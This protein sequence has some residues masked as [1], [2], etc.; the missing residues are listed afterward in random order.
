VTQ[1][2]PNPTTT[3][4]HAS[5]A[6]SDWAAARGEKWRHQLVRMEA[7]LAPVDDPLLRALHLAGPCR[8]ADLGCGGGGTG[9]ELLRRAPPGSAIHGFDISP[10][11]ID[12]ARARTRPDERAVAFA[13]T[14]VATAPAPEER[15]D[16]LVSRFGVMFYDD[17]AAAFANLSRWL[18]P[19]GRFAFAVWGPPADNPWHTTV[20]EA[21]A[22][23]VD[24]PPPDPEAPGPFRYADAD[25]LLALLEPEG[26]GELAVNDWRGTLPLG[27]GLP[28]AEAAR[29]ALAAFSVGELLA[30]AG[31]AALEAAWRALTARYAR[32][33]R[34]GVVRLDACV[35][36]VT[37]ARVR[38]QVMR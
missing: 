31:D 12:A 6:G 28:A 20:R 18:V 5:T 1:P 23:L 11:L 8:I 19:A 21:A 36:I 30:G 37:G 17:P 16:R 24:V 26:L 27:G 22:E 10:A 32:H 13:V 29:F 33:E 35:H 14:D 7:M 38:D 4:H 2:P 9:L 25:R 3:S 15:Y 34:G